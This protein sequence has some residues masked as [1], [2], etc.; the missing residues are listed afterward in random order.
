[1]EHRYLSKVTAPVTLGAREDMGAVNYKFFSEPLTMEPQHHVDV[2]SLEWTSVT[3]F[4]LLGVAPS[5]APNL[6]NSID[7]FRDATAFNHDV[8]VL[9]IATRVFS[10]TY[11]VKNP[12]GGSVHPVG[13]SS[14]AVKV[15]KLKEVISDV[16]KM[17][18]QASPLTSGLVSALDSSDISLGQV[19]K[20]G[21]FVDA[22]PTFIVYDGIAG[23]EDE[24]HDR[25]E[26]LGDDRLPFLTY[27][28]FTIMR[29]SRGRYRDSMLKSTFPI[30]P[31]RQ[32]YLEGNRSAMVELCLHPGFDS[33]M[34][35]SVRRIV[36][37][38]INHP[39]SFSNRCGNVVIQ[40]NGGLPPSDEFRRRTLNGAPRVLPSLIGENY[41]LD[42]YNETPYIESGYI[43]RCPDDLPVFDVSTVLALGCDPQ[44][45]VNIYNQFKKAIGGTALA[46]HIIR[47][48][49][50][51]SFDTASSVA[52]RI[53]APPM[54]RV[55]AG[56]VEP[57]N[58]K[59]MLYSPSIYKGKPDEI[60]NTI[61]TPFSVIPVLKSWVGP[62][63]STSALRNGLWPSNSD[64][65]RYDASSEN[66]RVGGAMRDL[67]MQY[68]LNTLGTVL[69]LKK[70]VVV[71]DPSSYI[72]YAVNP[73][74]DSEVV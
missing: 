34:F 60:L 68:N 71:I 23:T 44:R 53:V 51:F 10:S 12:S 61:N 9:K 59:A 58:I 18:P 37:P 45:V 64:Y 73:L 22:E 74:F 48:P 54:P 50:S 62:Y 30:F 65:S 42:V 36:T 55:E 26:E 69:S 47:M 31:A 35:S 3:A 13:A 70:D 29:E 66:F 15:A 57:P 21:S 63:I 19:W 27:K 17:F 40:P 4:L 1:M 43:R 24:N 6:S 28:P 2:V 11:M 7:L 49:M 56:Y 14:T 38:Y 20:P 41:I 8:A 32:L 72:K 25:V 46:P 5:T 52:D 39:L 33:H 16:Q 67:S